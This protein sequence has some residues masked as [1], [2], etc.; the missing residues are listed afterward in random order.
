MKIVDVCKCCSVDVCKCCFCILLLVLLVVAVWYFDRHDEIDPYENCIIVNNLSAFVHCPDLKK[1]NPIIYEENKKPTGTTESLETSSAARNT[2]AEYTTPIALRNFTTEKT[3]LTATSKNIT[4]GSETHWQEGTTESPETSSAARNTSVEYTT[5][6][7]LR[8]FTTEKNSL[9]AASTN[10]TTGGE[11][12]D[13]SFYLNCTAV[14]FCDF[15]LLCATNRTDLEDRFKSRSRTTVIYRHGYSPIY[16]MFFHYPTGGLYGWN[17]GKFA[18]KVVKNGAL[19]TGGAVIG[20]K[21]TKHKY[22]GLDYASKGFSIVLEFEV[23]RATGILQ[24][25][26]WKYEID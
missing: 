17:S 18:K 14:Y 2:S 12:Q 20:H 8:N 26:D 24:K 6:I 19:V 13:L 23:A 9:T 7:A 22:N 16:P 25:I 15:G 21:L 3:S 1:C 11:T 10:T 4:A 5:P